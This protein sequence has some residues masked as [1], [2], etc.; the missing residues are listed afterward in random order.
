MFVKYKLEGLR[1][2][3]QREV[4]S[5]TGARLRVGAVTVHGLRGLRIDGLEVT[6]GGPPG[7]TLRLTIPTAY[8]Y[9]DLGDLLN[10]VV[11][12]NRIE[13]DRSRICVTRMPGAPWFENDVPRSEGVAPL[14][15]ASPFRIV[16]KDCELEV[17]NLVGDARLDVRSVS[18]DVSRLSGS[19]DL[20]AK[21]V[22]Y[23]APDAAKSLKVDLRY[24]LVEDFDLRVHCSALTNDDIAL[25]LPDARKI[26]E[27]GTVSP[28]L[29]VAG[30][31][32]KTLVVAFETPFDEVALRG[33]PDFLRPL[34]GVLSG[35]AQYDMGRRLVTLTAAKADS[36][37]LAGRIDGTVSFALDRPQFDLRLVTT[38]LPVA[39]VLSYVMEQ[40]P[41]AFGALDLT[42]DEP[43]E[44][45]ATLKGTM[46]APV[47]SFQGSAASGTFSLDPKDTSLPRGTLTLGAVSVSWS[48]DQPVP[49]GSFVVTDGTLFHE[50]SALRAEHVTGTLTAEN[51]RVHIEPLNAE[52]TGQPFVGSMT[53]DYDKG[54]LELALNGTISG[55]EKTRL[56]AYTGDVDISGALGLRGN[57]V[58]DRR[59]YTLDGDVD[60]TQA[61]IAYP[62]WFMKPVGLAANA[63]NVHAE[64]VARRPVA[65]TANVELAGS[66][67]RLKADTATDKRQWRLKSVETACDKFDVGPVG[68]CLDIAYHVTGGVGTDAAFTW[69]R[70]DGEDKAWTL[71]GG[72]SVD[73]ASLH[74]RDN[75]ATADLEGV[76]VE[77]TI[78]EG[79]RPDGKLKLHARKAAVP[80]LRTKW[81]IPLRPNNPSERKW[82]CELSADSL[83]LPPWRGTSFSGQA[84]W[85]AAE[86]GFSSFAADLDGGGHTQGTYKNNKLDNAYDLAC[87]WKEIQAWYLLDQLNYPRVLTG[88]TTGETKYFLDRDDPGTLK[89]TAHFDVHDGHFSAD[90]IL[91]QLEGGLDKK[92]TALPPSLKFASLG[93]DIVFQGDTITTP[94]LQLVSE[95]VKIGVN[96]SYKWPSRRIWRNAFPRCAT[97]FASRVC[98]SRSR[99]SNS[100]FGSKVRA[101]IP[102]AKWP[103]C[104]P[105]ALRSSAARSKRPATPSA[106]SISLENF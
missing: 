91:A 10:G 48:P 95:G 72:L 97:T 18:F 35:V 49:V 68:T 102:K 20:A 22:G 41:E 50:A 42:L 6:L 69:R 71:S 43:C 101:S 34:T 60:A 37:Q 46:D 13:M 105:W 96:G 39:D 70:G 74:P 12:V 61:R 77:M 84:F 5:R 45:M 11:T 83:E 3:A 23:L 33:Q 14:A 78:N 52:I 7:T 19:T 89:G 2:A 65:L 90:F 4:E 47:F 51:K 29:R 64:I 66:R 67:I 106:S 1:G 36:D 9:P 25:L 53:Y 80:P 21:I 103:R 62:G 99:I 57:L 76:S 88:K 87:Q 32:G 8:V 82:T 24:T 73:R 38:R 26:L 55:V 58:K 44:V 98:V 31:P 81:L 28:S 94:N 56:R 92:I 15:G 40:R 17:A 93:S 16:G 27:S 100:R 59:G 54:R 63:R 30:Y 75:D 85:S 86:S 79:E 104:P